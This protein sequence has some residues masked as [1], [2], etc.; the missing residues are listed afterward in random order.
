VGRE[1][2]YC[3]DYAIGFIKELK[4]AEIQARKGKVAESNRYIET[5]QEML[6]DLVKAG[7]VTQAVAAPTTDDLADAHSETDLAKKAAKARAIVGTIHYDLA[8]DIA[9]FCQTKKREE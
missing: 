6:N 4:E 7:C 9:H 5:A 3:V 8:T 1:C 2:R